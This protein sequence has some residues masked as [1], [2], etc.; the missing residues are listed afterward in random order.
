MDRLSSQMDR[1]ARREIK[2]RLSSV[3]AV[4]L[5]LPSLVIAQDSLLVDSIAPYPTLRVRSF[6]EAHRVDSLWSDSL[7]IWS[8]ACEGPLR[9]FRFE[10]PDSTFCALEF[11]CTREATVSSELN[12]P[13]SSASGLTPLQSWTAEVTVALDDL[14]AMPRKPL[15]S[16]CFPPAASTAFEALLS[17]MEQ[18]V[19]E[20]E[21]CAVLVRASETLCLTRSQ[22]RQA[23]DRIASEDRKL[24]TLERIYRSDIEW[25]EAELR[26]LFQLNFILEQALKRFTKR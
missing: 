17:A 13:L 2:A 6:G 14:K 25:T 19:F 5:G 1:K 3:A 22:M 11:P 24:D 10:F 21:K 23:L 20:T 4:V 18:A 8:G 16:S 9:S 7:W 26:A 15:A 12:A